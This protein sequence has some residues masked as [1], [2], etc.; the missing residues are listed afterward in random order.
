MSK[1]CLISGPPGCGKTTWI[2]NAMRN[3]KGA[4]GY[5]RLPGFPEEGIEVTKDNSIDLT[6]LIDQLPQLRHLSDPNL[7]LTS[8]PNDLLALI[9][10]TQCHLPKELGLN[11]L[12][13]RIKAQLKELNLHPDR[14]LHFGADS[15]L[16]AHDT[17]KFNQLETLTFHL[18]D[19]V[20]DP[21]SLSSYWFELVNGAYG[22]VYRAKALMNLPDGRAYFCNWMMTQE[23]SQFLPLQYVAP[24]TGRPKRGSALVVQGKALDAVGMQ[25]TIDDCLLSDEVLEMQ[26]APLRN[27]QP[28]HSHFN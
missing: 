20:W 26:Q 16:P 7:K 13:Q 18:R 25:T 17:L 28:V 27:Q 14:I 2:L 22:D 11:G 6:W 12:D 23:G 5:L 8:Q 1:I 9:E 21:N 24:P 15:E 3:H 4:C 19:S 10:M